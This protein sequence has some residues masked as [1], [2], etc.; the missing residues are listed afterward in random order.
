MYN[1]NLKKFDLF[2]IKKRKYHYTTTARTMQG[3]TALPWSLDACDTRDPPGRQ[4]RSTAQLPLP[5]DQGVWEGDV[6]EVNIA[7]M[8]SCD[9]L[10]RCRCQIIKSLSYLILKFLATNST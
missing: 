3:P 10:L 8:S 6:N 2:L 7:A 9:M 5:T 1:T 4:G